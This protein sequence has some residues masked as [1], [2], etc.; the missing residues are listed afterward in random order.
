M[1]RLRTCAIAC[2]LALA[3]VLPGCGVK[4]PLVPAKKGTETG[5]PPPPPATTAPDIPSAT[6]PS[7]PQPAP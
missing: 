2:M 3:C 7:N 6:I 4:G 1:L 5:A